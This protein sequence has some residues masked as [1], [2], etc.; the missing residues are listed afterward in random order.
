MTTSTTENNTQA[1]TENIAAHHKLEVFNKFEPRNFSDLRQFLLQVGFENLSPDVYQSPH[2]PLDDTE[3]ASGRIIVAFSSYGEITVS[4]S[5]ET[6]EV[7]TSPTDSDVV[8][9]LF[10]LSPI[11]QE[12][13]D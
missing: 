8:D 7:Y 2:T 10:G 4:V 6:N 12:A 13:T 3:F 11:F 1:T 9:F 5:K